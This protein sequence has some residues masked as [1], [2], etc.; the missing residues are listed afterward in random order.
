MFHGLCTCYFWLEQLS[1][2]YITHL[3]QTR[4]CLH[5]CLNFSYSLNKIISSVVILT[6]LI[7]F[8]I[9]AIIWDYI[10]LFAYHF[11]RLNVVSTRFSFFGL[12]WFP[13]SWNTLSHVVDLQWILRWIHLDF[14]S[15]KLPVFTPLYTTRDEASFLKHRWDHVPQPLTLSFK[16][17]RSQWCPKR[18]MKRANSH[19][20]VHKSCSD[21]CPGLIS[22]FISYNSTYLIDY[23]WELS[24]LTYI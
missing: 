16:R 23:F 22:R 14:S 24:M 9:I 11:T 8:Q 18:S 4:S 15:T 1:S 12:C 7:V 3:Q 21:L 19:E 6:H 10:L 13:S 5:L 2:L 17:N 20:L